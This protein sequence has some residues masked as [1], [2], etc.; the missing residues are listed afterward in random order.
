MEDTKPQLANITECYNGTGGK[1]QLANITECYNGTGG[2]A[3][4]KHNGTGGG[5]ESKQQLAIARTRD[6]ALGIGGESFL[7][8]KDIMNTHTRTHTHIYDKTLI[9]SSFNCIL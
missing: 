3:E 4:S 9:Y 8:P 5:A 6:S 7:F 1:L 2:G